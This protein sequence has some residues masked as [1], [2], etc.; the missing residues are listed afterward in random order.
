MPTHTKQTVETVVKKIDERRK[1][2]KGKPRKFPYGCDQCDGYGNIVTE[3][4][5]RA[6]ECKKRYFIQVHLEQANIPPIFEDKSFDTFEN[7][8]PEHEKDLK[9]AREYVKNY[10]S[11]NKRGV[12]FIGHP[13]VGKTHLAISILREL[14][15]KGYTG[16]FFNMNDLLQ[17][18]RATFD[19]NSS[20]TEFDIL[21]RLLGVDVL[22]LDD[23]G[24]QER[25]SGFV[26]DRFYTLVNGRYQA[27]KTLIVTTNS[28]P[29][30]LEQRLQAHTISRLYEICE[31]RMASV[32][33]DYRT[34]NYAGS[35][36]PK[37]R[38]ARGVRRAGHPEGL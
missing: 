4:G 13:G 27:N 14:I 33:T 35:P 18:I 19:E 16:L 12:L 1:H 30:T 28:D 6:C 37:K 8:T 29:K 15:L 17:E 34:S 36:G 26:L 38:G 7:P 22:V 10:S 32:E 3:Q 24:A 11:T 2:P 31:L 20:A 5:A 23:V 9:W 21:E 25:I